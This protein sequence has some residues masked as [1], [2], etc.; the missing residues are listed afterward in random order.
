MLVS[1][2]KTVNFKFEKVDHTLIRKIVLNSC[3]KTQ[4]KPAT[5]IP[6][7]QSVKEEMGF[8]DEFR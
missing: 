3:M 5:C 6:V 1:E 4:T 2:S 8:K 7:Q